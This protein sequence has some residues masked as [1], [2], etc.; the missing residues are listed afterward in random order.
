MMVSFVIPSR[1]QAG[2]IER[3][4]DS[5]LA[6]DSHERE[7]IV[8]DGASTDKTQSL[9]SAYGSRIQWLSEP[10][11]GQSDAVN[12]GIAKARGEIIAWIN[13]DDYYPDHRLLSH[14]MEK[15]CREPTL[16][17]IHGDGN[18]VDS[19]GA[20]IRRFRSSEMT[21][22]REMLLRAGIGICQPALF[23]RRRLF[24]EA[25]GLNIHLHWA[26]D[27]D[28][29]LR[30]FPLA[31]KVSYLNEVLACATCHPQAKSIAGMWPHI[32]EICAVLRKYQGQHSWTVAERLKL[33]RGKTAL[34]LY[35][36][37]VRLHLKKVI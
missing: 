29:W 13:S 14:I 23:F 31:R 3:C 36:L 35:G 11:R 32:H 24:L 21:S 17:I 15:F 22:S 1:N 37:A 16:D 25:G 30:L 33:W 12:K 34:Y 5:C 27:L 9:L 10:D 26:M 18:L 20:V 8:M 4:L 6:L 2:F 28:L 7:V 19:K